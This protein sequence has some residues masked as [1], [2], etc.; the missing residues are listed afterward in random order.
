MS[1]RIA[2]IINSA[3]GIGYTTEWA[4]ELAARFRAGGLEPRVTLAHSGAEIVDAARC[5]VSDRLQTVVAGGGDGT[6]NAVASALIGSDI[7]LGVLALGTLNHFAKDLR[8]PLELDAAVRTVIA[9]HCAK[10]DAG[11]VNRKIFLNNSSI[12]LYADVVSKREAGQRRWGV[13]KWPAFF[14]AMI[15]AMR[16]YPFLHVQLTIDGRKYESRTPCLFVG[17]N[18]YA[19]N[20][21]DIGERPSMSTGLLSVYIVRSQARI[22]LLTLAV[23][24]LSGRLRHTKDF[25]AL[26][27]TEIVIETR[28]ARKRVAIDGEVAMMDTPLHYRTR[29]GAL[30]VIVPKPSTAALGD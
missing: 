15:G 19:M 10:V 11:E 7:P 21:F 30:R 14:W 5:A 6:I 23:R 29:P 3:A 20:G 22:A 17:N 12:G 26:L 25:E 16:R 1:T 18:A 27:T 4:D 9:G 24:A 13:G 2:V 8:I 28:H